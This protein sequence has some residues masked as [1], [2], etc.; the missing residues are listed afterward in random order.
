MIGSD[1][2]ADAPTSRRLVEVAVV[3]GPLG[4]T[5]VANAL[6]GALAGGP[7]MAPVPVGPADTGYLARVRAA[8]RADDVD[9]PL[10]SDDVVAV[11]A[12][13][14]STG[15]PKGVLITEAAI[16]AAVTGFHGAFGGPAHWVVAMPVHAVGGLMVV[17][18]SV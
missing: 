15:D 16:R 3:P 6:S 9:A 5:A 12:T 8:L 2:P 1:A 4:V 13:S 10:E 11:I 17:A 18:R 14:G 7:A